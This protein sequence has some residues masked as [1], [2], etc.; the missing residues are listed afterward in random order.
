[1]CEIKKAFEYHLNEYG[2]CV[3]SIGHFVSFIVHYDEHKRLQ[4]NLEDDPEL[5]FSITIYLNAF[6]FR[7][8]SSKL[9]PAHLITYRNLKLRLSQVFYLMINRIQGVIDAVR[10]IKHDE[11]IKNEFI[12][13]LNIIIDDIENFAKKV[14]PHFKHSL[15]LCNCCNQIIK[16]API[17]DR[18]GGYICNSCNSSES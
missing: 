18:W 3:K 11:N 10:S 12:N 16:D 6:E 4:I 13:L 14:S 2:V 1:M 15:A 7:R 8:L 9:Y 17:E 5:A